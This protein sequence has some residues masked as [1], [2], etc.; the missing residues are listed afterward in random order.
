M[1]LSNVISGNSYA[2]VWISA[3]SQNVVAGNA[4]GVSED[5]THSVAN[6]EGVYILSGATKNTIGGTTAGSLNVI[7]GNSSDG[8]LVAS[9]GTTGNVIAGNNIGT[10]ST[11]LHSLPNTWGVYV[12]GGATDNTFGGSTS[13]ARNLIS[14]NYWTGVE[15]NGSGTSGNVVEGNWIG[16]NSTGNAGLANPGAGVAISQGANSNTILSNLISGNSYAGVWISASSQNVVAGNSIGLSHDGTHNVPNADGVDLLNDAT[17]NTIGGTASGSRNV[18]SGNGGSGVHIT[19]SGTNGNVVEGNYIG[20]DASGGYGNVGDA[21]Y[22]VQID[23]GASS[24]TVGSTSYAGRNVISGNGASG[25]FIG[26]VG[27]TNNVV[28]GNY[29]GTDSTGLYPVGNAIDGVDIANG[30]TSNAIG[31]SVSGVLNVISANK[32]EGVWITGAGTSNNVVAGN[33]IGTV[34]SGAGPLGNGINGI[35]IDSG[36]FGNLIGGSGGFSFNMIAYNGSN[37]VGIGAGSYGN[38]IDNDYISL[39]GSNGVYFAGTS[40]NS[41]VGCTI[42]ANQAWGILDQGSDNYYA[43]NTIYNNIDGS[44]GY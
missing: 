6:G 35:Q 12:T 24:N 19:G 13:A 31:G 27:T 2:G 40:G 4:I 23:S 18:I 22:G 1:I 32:Y 16:T 41:V 37:G 30:A 28:E 14:G 15:L 3:S 7:S 20:V 26:S 25:V 34:V 21:G 29:I 33:D 36:A 43:Y 10:G 42:E 9:V 8:V 39:N 17:S 38:T 11:G 5:G 44:I